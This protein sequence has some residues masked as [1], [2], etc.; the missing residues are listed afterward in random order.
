MT[1]EDQLTLDAMRADKEIDSMAVEDYQRHLAITHAAMG[2]YMGI[3]SDAMG[4]VPPI[5]PEEKT[6]RFSTYPGERPDV[7]VRPTSSLDELRAHLQT[8][9]AFVAKLQRKATDAS[10]YDDA[11]DALYEMDLILNH[12]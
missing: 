1:A 2:D 9:T 7:G 11:I 3:D 12:K 6:V 5:D 4:Y 10:A 8:V